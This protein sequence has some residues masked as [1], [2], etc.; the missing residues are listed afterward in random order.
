MQYADGTEPLTD[1]SPPGPMGEVHVE[2]KK[3]TREWLN[4]AIGSLEYKLSTTPRADAVPKWQ[5]Q[6][7]GLRQE[8]AKLDDAESRIIRFGDEYDAA[9][10]ALERAEAED[11]ARVEALRADWKVYLFC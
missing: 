11:R 9:H 6:I 3:K 2:H 10:D 4:G 8:I 7:E 1:H 5:G